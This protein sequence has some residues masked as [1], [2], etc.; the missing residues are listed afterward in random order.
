[1]WDHSLIRFVIR[2]I[3]AT[4]L[5]YQSTFHSFVTTSSSVLTSNST[6]HMNRVKKILNHRHQIWDV[7]SRTDRRTV[8]GM[9][10]EQAGAHT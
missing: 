6:D 7:W 1:M 3:E 2:S 10:E 4:P 5:L 9:S 8:S